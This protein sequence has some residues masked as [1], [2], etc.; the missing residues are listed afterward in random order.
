MHFKY[1]RS[2]SVQLSQMSCNQMFCA[3]CFF[4][5]RIRPSSHFRKDLEIYAQIL[6]RKKKK[7]GL[8]YQMRVLSQWRNLF[9]TCSGFRSRWASVLYLKTKE[10]RGMLF[11]VVTHC[12]RGEARRC[13]CVCVYGFVTGGDTYSSG[14]LDLQLPKVEWSSQWF[15]P[16]RL[17]LIIFLTVD[18]LKYCVLFVSMCPGAWW[19]EVHVSRVKI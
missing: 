4:T 7:I 15:W 12:K 13:V 9:T 10:L 16:V 3:I 2:N 5:Y 18:C 19:S 1:N 6:K 14:F 17:M 11:H 8:A